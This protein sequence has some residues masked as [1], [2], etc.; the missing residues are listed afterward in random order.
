MEEH[1]LN[2]H[3][4]WCG[5]LVQWDLHVQRTLGNGDVPTASPKRPPLP[6]KGSILPHGGHD[7]KGSGDLDPLTAECGGGS[8]DNYDSNI[9]SSADLSEAREGDPGPAS[10]LC[11]TRGDDGPAPADEGRDDVCNE[12]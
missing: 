4:A 12:I 9:E 7:E 2:L 8:D 11:I 3:P 10:S 1:L 5:T 6:P